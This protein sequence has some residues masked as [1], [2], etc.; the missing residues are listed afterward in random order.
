DP[1]WFKK[2]E[3]VGVTAGASTPDYVIEEVERRIALL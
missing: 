1:E 3:V 2:A